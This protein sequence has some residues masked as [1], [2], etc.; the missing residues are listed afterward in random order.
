M[1]E[2]DP[3]VDVICTPPSQTFSENDKI[4]VDDYIVRVR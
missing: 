3:E 4:A 1:L 2:L